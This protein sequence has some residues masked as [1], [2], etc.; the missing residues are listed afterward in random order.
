MDRGE[1]THSSCLQLKGVGNLGCYMLCIPGS[2]TVSYRG[3]SLF[4]YMVLVFHGQ[5]MMF[6]ILYYACVKIRTHFAHGS[7]PA[8]LDLDRRN[9]ILCISM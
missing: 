9:S 4:L 1:S 8:M 3:A 2:V 5:G 7:V 6:M